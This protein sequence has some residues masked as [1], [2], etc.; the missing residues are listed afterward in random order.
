MNIIYL[1]IKE[2]RTN[3]GFSRH[4]LKAFMNPDIAKLAEVKCNHHAGQAEQFTRYYIDEVR[5]N[6]SEHLDMEG[7]VD[8]VWVK[9][10]YDNEYI[11]NTQY[12]RAEAN[13]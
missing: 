6:D 1:L 3:S 12:E 5:L 8:E 4:T 2:E 9:D 7:H 10:E 13:N 11:F